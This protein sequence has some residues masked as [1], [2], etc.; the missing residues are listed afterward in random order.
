MA[1]TTGCC[2]SFTHLLG[3]LTTTLINGALEFVSDV[4]P[5]E[6]KALVR[7]TVELQDVLGTFQDAHVA[8]AR[9]RELAA[10]RGGELGPE[11]V[12]AMG[13]VAERYRSGTAD[14]RGSVAKTFAGVDG[15]AWKRLRQRMNAARPAP[16]PL[17]PVPKPAPQEVQQGA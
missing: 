13:E 7:K 12:F 14:I 11:A 10:E 5:G 3:V 4:Y 15:K 2:S 17:P 16:P 9:L 1:V 8:M 6:T